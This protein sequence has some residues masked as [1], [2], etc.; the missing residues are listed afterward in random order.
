MGKQISKQYAHQRIY[1]AM[2][3]CLFLHQLHNLTA[4][5]NF[6]KFIK[7]LWKKY[8]LSSRFGLACKGT[9]SLHTDISIPVS[10]HRSHKE[11]YSTMHEDPS[12]RIIR[13]MHTINI[14]V[15]LVWLLFSLGHFVR[16]SIFN[17]CSIF[18]VPLDV[19]HCLRTLNQGLLNT[20]NNYSL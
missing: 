9:L 7:Y 16:A 3:L 13:I 17:C 10:F 11:I 20:S 4:S 1:L 12:V 2:Y 6:S 18:N 8:E 19:H 14:F 15:I 5:T